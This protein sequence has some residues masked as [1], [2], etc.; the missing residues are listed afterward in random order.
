MLKGVAPAVA[1]TAGSA[2]IEM[3][4]NVTVASLDWLLTEISQVVSVMVP[5]MVMVPSAAKAEPAKVK[6][7][8]AASRVVL[9][10]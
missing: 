5:L 8:T 10:L 6:P 3:V 1:P 7:I 4:G 2:E 9:V